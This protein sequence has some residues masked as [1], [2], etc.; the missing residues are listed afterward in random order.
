MQS[1]I[2]IAGGDRRMDYGAQ[3]LKRGMP[4]WHVQR[5]LEEQ[6]AVPWDVLVLSLGSKPSRELLAAG[7]P[8][9]LVLVANPGEELVQQ[10]T[11]AG[12]AWENYMQREEL[13]LRNAVPTAEGA[14]AVALSETKETLDGKGALILGYGRIGKALAP[15][16]RGLG[17]AVTVCARRRESR[18]MAQLAL[19]HAISPE[20]MPEAMKN[21][22]V[23]F[24]TVPAPMLGENL[25]KALPAESLVVDLASRPGGT[26]FDAAKRLGVPAV[27]A[28]AL[29]PVVWCWH[30][31][32]KKGKNRAVL[33]L[34]SGIIV[35]MLQKW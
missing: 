21:T 25:L 35:K 11:E 17:M 22:L 10:L 14:I 8:G 19:C 23:V 32:G 4:D 13:C 27:W 7:K 30:I 28:L 1:E 9:G 18:I 34:K 5:V 26:D 31:L 6:E 15:R 2:V 24:N 3:A 29:P 20:A 16:L 33:A 12:L